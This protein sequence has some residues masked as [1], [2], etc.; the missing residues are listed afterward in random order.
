MERT[1]VNYPKKR[2]NEEGCQ[3]QLSNMKPTSSQICFS[4][5]RSLK[6]SCDTHKE[7]KKTHV[8]RK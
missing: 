7:R 8:K 1:H 6:I 3:L 4:K 2:K 5:K